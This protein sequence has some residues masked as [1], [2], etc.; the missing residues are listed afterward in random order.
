MQTKVLNGA[1][2]MPVL[3]TYVSA[4]GQEPTQDMSNRK[5]KT[6]GTLWYSSAA[7]LY[8]SRSLVYNNR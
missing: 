7:Y 1:A 2:I 3:R 6:E 5:W 4:G 8:F